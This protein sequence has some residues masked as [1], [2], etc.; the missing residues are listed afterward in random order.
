MERISERHDELKQLSLVDPIEYAEFLNTPSDEVAL[1]DISSPEVQHIIDEMLAMASGKH[2]EGGAQMVGL[3][4]PQV[5]EHK[6]IV[7]IDTNAD[8]VERKDEQKMMVLI[9]PRIVAAS[10][11][12][13]DGREGCWSCDNYCA[14]VPRPEWV[15]IEAYDREG[16]L[17]QTRLEGF[18]GRI[19][20][21]E[22][23]HLDGVRCID[24][25]P[26]DE[27]WRLHYVDKDDLEQ[28]KRYR[29]EWRTWK[30][31]FSLEDWLKFRR[32]ERPEQREP[33]ST[34]KETQQ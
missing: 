8:G 5:G 14:N 12:L 18:T 22:I 25:V 28:F 21:H 11:T 2:Q 26:E 31:H 13:E 20:Q 24:R 29:K 30:N 10:E 16:N 33:V 34:R 17:V 19:A 27:P 4:A 1:E 32:G 6:R 9:N 7:V 15:D 3:A 23:D